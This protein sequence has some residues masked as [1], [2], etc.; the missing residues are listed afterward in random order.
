MVKKIAFVLAFTLMIVVLVGC[1][2]KSPL[3]GVW[4]NEETQSTYEFKSNGEGIIKFFGVELAFDY[5]DDGK[6]IV[7]TATGD[8]AKNLEEAG[9]SITD[10]L[11]YDLQDDELTLG[12]ITFVKTE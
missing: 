1:G 9:E 6:S 2:N 10:I 5:V 11:L 12:G 7:M 4:E 8:V 3:V